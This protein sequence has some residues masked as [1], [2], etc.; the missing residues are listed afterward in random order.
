MA[1]ETMQSERRGTNLDEETFFIYDLFRMFWTR[2]VGLFFREI[3]ERNAHLIPRTGPVIFVVAPHHNQFVD[4]VILLMHAVRRV[5][6]LVAAASMRRRFIG[7]YGRCMRG[8]SVE[9]QQDL[10]KTGTG[11]IRVD[12]RYGE[13]TLITGL[14]TRFATEIKP[15]MKVALPKG[16]GEAKVVE[17]LSD[18]QLRVAK[19][20]K[21]LAAMELLTRTDGTS[22][23]V[24]PHVD[25][26]EMFH[27]VYQR[28][29]NGECVGIFPEGGSHDR[30]EM[31]PL[32]AGATIMAL[33]ATAANPELGLKIVP[34]GL[35]YFHPSKFRSRAV[36]DFGQPIDIPPELVE[37]YR[38]GGAAKR[39]ACD[40]LL[41]VVSEGLKQVTLNTPDYETL[42]MVQAGRRL[43]QPT[44][45]SLTMAQQVELTRRFIKGYSVYRDLPEVKELRDRI[46]DYN[47]QLRYYGIRDHQVDT[48]RIGRAEAG[49]LFVWRLLWLLIMGLVALPGTVLN[50]PVFIVT[51]VVSKKKAR[52]ALAA[53]TVKVRARDVIATWKILIALGL[54]PLL[55]TTYSVLAVLFVRRA[56]LWAAGLVAGIAD[57][58]SSR[59][60]LWSW[61]LAAFMSYTALV[62]GEQ[63]VD[64]VKSVRPLFL[65]LILGEE[66]TEL[67]ARQ[68]EELS[69]DITELV[70]ELGPK[71]Y[72]EFSNTRVPVDLLLGDGKKTHDN[73]INGSADAFHRK[74]RE[75][76]QAL[77]QRM[78]GGGSSSN[79]RQDAEDASSSASSGLRQRRPSKYSF[80]PPTPRTMATLNSISP[81]E[82][83]TSV[84]PPSTA[85]P[86]HHPMSDSPDCEEVET[87]ESPADAP[88][89]ETTEAAAPSAV[90]RTSAAAQQYQGGTPA[91]TGPSTPEPQNGMFDFS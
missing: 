39:E 77:R 24:V 25:Q 60:Y 26:D 20:M 69:D 89:P 18:T 61:A 35:N 42:K 63:A 86:P 41:R 40:E 67:L 11:R 75:G 2:V 32:K 3:A 37:Q 34:T 45:H 59:I 5:Y 57:W 52:A 15:G 80:S 73:I 29:N 90:S 85:Q 30:T 50:L 46:E 9:R 68:R 74:M 10:A 31:L 91:T 23:K 82:F 62:F 88:N 44:Q 81:L 48:M 66:H 22:F 79:L 56:P 27:S 78:G 54:V 55:Y 83:L 16:V 64:I 87:M 14:G 47:L 58:P 51:G 65:T 19:E 33:G 71:I 72:P 13:P 43:Y 70:N 36:I 49:A 6:F 84:A 4:P 17:V 38:K 1:G 21:E 76:E 28:L 8:I 53:S 7:F 12:D